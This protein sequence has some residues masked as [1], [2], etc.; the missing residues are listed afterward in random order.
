MTRD[1][2]RSSDEATRA[3]LVQLEIELENSQKR[4]VALRLAIAATELRFPPDNRAATRQVLA[5]FALG[6]DAFF[7][8]TTRDRTP[9]FFLGVIVIGVV[10]FVLATPK[11]LRGAMKRRADRG[12]LEEA[13]RT[14]GAVA[15]Q[16]AEAR[17]RLEPPV[18]DEDSEEDDEALLRKKI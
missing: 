4:V 16:I 18:P 3:R 17:S 13:E 2:Y 6:V 7:F 9:E 12:K 8:L 11:D 10:S 15:N 1:A 14:R 5:I